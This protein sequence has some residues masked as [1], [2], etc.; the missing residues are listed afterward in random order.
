MKCRRNKYK[1]LFEVYIFLVAIHKNVNEANL[2]TYKTQFLPDPG[3]AGLHQGFQFLYVC[4]LVRM[5]VSASQSLRLHGHYTLDPQ[6]FL[7]FW[8]SFK[9]TNR[10]T[11]YRWPDPPNPLYGG[12]KYFWGGKKL[13]IYIYVYIF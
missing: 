3:G 5:S 12:Q 2:H 9:V 1:Y 13:Y 4:P 8:A 10:G 11:D 7:R 6:Y